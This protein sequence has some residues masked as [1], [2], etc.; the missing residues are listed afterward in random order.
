M[1]STP[2]TLG[3]NAALVLQALTQGFAYGFEI[4]RAAHLPSGTVYPLLRRLDAQGLLE[5]SWEDA[6]QAH[7]EGRPP[8]RYYRA[9]K[10][11]RAALAEARER[12]SAQQVLFTDEGMAGE[13]GRGG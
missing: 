11:G 5:S 13:G 8:R 1:G 12:L 10:E 7:D 9:T 6:S 3:Y 4:M 2:P